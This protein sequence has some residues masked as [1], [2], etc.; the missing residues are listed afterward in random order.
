MMYDTEVKSAP[1][2]KN[3]TKR[4]L[5]S[6]IDPKVGHAVFVKD[7]WVGEY[8]R[9]VNPADWKTASKSVGGRSS[10][11]TIRRE[12]TEKFR[13]GPFSRCQESQK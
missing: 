3:T 8:A 12:T 10:E 7:D 11:L 2:S 6:I 13:P 9:S 1:V 5:S 4:L